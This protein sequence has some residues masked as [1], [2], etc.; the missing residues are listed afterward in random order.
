MFPFEAQHIVL[1]GVSGCGKSTIGQ[2]LSAATGL[3][4]LDGDDLHPVANV[5]KMRRGVP[6]ED[7]DRAPWLA[8]CGRRLAD[9]PSGL[10]LGCSALKAGYRSMIRRHASPA[11]PIFVYLHGSRPT[12]Q[13]R[14]GGRQDHFMP[15]ALLDSQI[16]TL[17]VP[18]P[19]EQAITVSIDQPAATVAQQILTRITRRLSPVARA[20]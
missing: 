6:L 12:L 7:A 11:V 5:E 19:G 17:D 10:I 15:K 2:A 9:A 20:A 16:A 14:L 18:A 13:M 4:Y 1:M 3:T 8:D